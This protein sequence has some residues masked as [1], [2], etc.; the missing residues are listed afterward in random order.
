MREVSRPDADSDPLIPYCT[1]EYVA[2]ESA[3]SWANLGQSGKAIPVLERALTTWPTT[4]RRDMGL[5]QAR[6]AA[7]HAER[8]DARRAVEAGHQAVA[9][10]RTATSAR[11][12]RELRRVREALMPWRRWSI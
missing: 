2:M 11:A 9:P 12:V 10:I 5:C 7:A 8:G 4:Q 1:L 6:L 3:A